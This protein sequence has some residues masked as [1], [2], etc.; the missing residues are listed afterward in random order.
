MNYC[1][2]LIL[3]LE[4]DVLE[5]GDVTFCLMGHATDVMSCQ[6][7]SIS[8]FDF[9]SSDFLS[10]LNFGQVTDIQN[11]MHMSPTCICTGGLKKG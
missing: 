6:H 11:T 2:V 3:C 5:K 9:L 10:S 1:L 7:V 8:L 4:T